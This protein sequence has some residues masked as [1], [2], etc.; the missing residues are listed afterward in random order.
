MFCEHFDPLLPQDI[1]ST[2]DLPSNLTVLL[3]RHLKN[4]TYFKGMTTRS[5]MQ[6]AGAS[7]G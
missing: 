2:R 6:N 7:N 1:S 4:E 3:T 5:F